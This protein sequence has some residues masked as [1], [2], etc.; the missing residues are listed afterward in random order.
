MGLMGARRLALVILAWLCVAGAL[1]FGG[2]PAGAAVTHEFLAGLSAKLN[3]GVPA[4]GPHGEPVAVPGP[5]VGGR[6]MTVDSGELYVAEYDF[7]NTMSATDKFDASSGAFLA[8]FP[9]V[10]SSAYLHQGITVGHSTGEAQVYVGGDEEGQKGA[11]AVLTP[12]GGVQAVWH[13][14][15]TPSGSFGCFECNASASIA[16]DANPSSLGDWAAGD[17]YVTD[18]EHRVVDVFKPLPGGGEEYVGQLTGPEAGSFNEPLRVAVEPLSGVVLVDDLGPDESTASIYMFKPAPVAG[19]Y[20]FLGKLEGPP[21]TGAFKQQPR[22]G[23]YLT[24]DAS[25]GDIYVA[26]R[27]GQSFVNEFNTQGKYLGRL[28]GTPREP[29]HAVE[30][31][32]VDAASHDVYVA[33]YNEKTN[34]TS[35]DAFGR[36]LVIPDVTTGVVSGLRAS[37]GEGRIEA[38][39]NG[40]V[41]PDGEGQASCW[42]AWGATQG[43][44]S[45]APCEPEKVADGSGAVAVHATLAAG[46]QPDTTYYYR[47]QA[48]N[49][50]GVNPGEPWQDR[51]FTTPGPGLHEESV[52]D[53]ASTSATLDAAISPHG[54]PT[55]YYFEYGT[56]TAYG[57]QAP[58]APGAPLGSGE[59]NVEVSQHVQGLAA[60]AVYHYRVAAVSELEPG[61]LETFAGP[62][63]TFTTQPAGPRGSGLLDGRSWE[64]VSP[65]N[66]HGARILPIGESGLSQSSAGGDA[67]TYL[68]ASPTEPEPQ[69]YAEQV[70][71]LSVRGADGWI[72]RDITPPHESPTG[73]S[74]GQGTEY[75]FFSEDLSLAVLQPF[76]GFV[77]ASSPLALAPG[78]ASEQTPFLHSD[79]L[80]GDVASLCVTSCY[81]PLVTGAE[82]HANVPPGTKFAPACERGV[83]CG[84]EF[85]GSSPDGSHVILGSAVPLTPGANGEALYEW[86][87]GRLA[88]VSVLPESEEPASKPQLGFENKVARN[89]VSDDGSRVVWSTNVYAGHLYLRDMRASQTLQ[90]DAVQGGSGNGSVGPVFQAAS[91]D[92]S[93]VFFTD[94]Q[95][96]TPESSGFGRDVYEC[97]VV[98]AEGKLACRL[99]DLTVTGTSE[100]A[101]V[102]GGVLGVS[103]DGSWAYFIANGVLAPGSVPG[104]C[105][106]SVSRADA[107]CNLYAWHEGSLRLVAVLSGRDWADWGSGKSVGNV[108]D[109]LAGLTGRVSPNGRWLAFMSQRSLTGYDTRDAVSGQ[110]DEEVYLYSA[111]AEGGS[112]RVLCAS[113]DPTGAR[114]AGVEYA[115]VSGALVGGDR[116]W[117]GDQWLAANIPGWTPYT[118]GAALHQSRYLSDSGR[119]FFNSS[120]ALVPQDVNGEQ[121]VYEFEPPGVGACT[122]ASVGYSERS[123][124]C[125][126][127]VSSGG[128]PGE[129]AFL[130]ASGTGGDAFFLTS[131][132]LVGQDYDTA[133]D[134]YDA[135]ECTSASPCFASPPVASPPCVTGD[136]CKPAP[137]PQPAIFGSPASATFS[138]QGN[139]T[140][141]P[142]GVTQ[143][144]LSRAQKLRR[145]LRACHRVKRRRPRLACERTARRRY[146]RAASLAPRT[147]SKRGG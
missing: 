48:A 6:S 121:D 130:D 15:D 135:H 49:K 55:S 73:V 50:N 107:T 125:V 29:F 100:G 106:G 5:L 56:S 90:L 74:V 68:T 16:V 65:A 52:S 146:A 8:Q 105:S 47:L 27:E 140:A 136:S 32:A 54:V 30:A 58:L 87:N 103:D 115:S 14:S 35:I 64:I 95:Q 44:G 66:K 81:R 10:S 4:V 137:T 101:D 78:E 1:L 2:A 67:M 99:S 84:P 31:V 98:E 85:L 59:A 60:G 110:P 144:R 72:A 109:D 117:S 119:L 127:L 24:V 22:A 23:N 133:L 118:S 94:S 123:G 141:K 147:S 26:A 19:Q 79:Y 39:L 86:S 128:A 124:G 138:G 41:D 36:N 18:P 96:L 33:D 34:V 3:E 132:K 70:Q 120:D 88:L 12:S 45:E 97:E 102:Q 134:V 21:P 93:R 53:V 75:R 129:S 112:G 43:L 76:G 13:G 25:N 92:G 20:E 46:L 57:A 122:S 139:V 37:G 143:R 131:G 71:V 7:V 51:Q 116:V 91:A 82:G 111:D 62:D 89:A 69:G 9:Q 38:T 28:A 40:T 145:A 80:N 126:G 113:C 61:V 104:K 42:F 63:Q 83:F 108:G 17:V 11:V 142:P 114:P 77:P